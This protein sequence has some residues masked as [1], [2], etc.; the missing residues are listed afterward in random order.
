MSAVGCYVFSSRLLSSTASCHTAGK[1]KGRKKSKKKAAD[2]DSVFAALD[3]NGTSEN[4]DANT[5]TTRVDAMTNGTQPDVEADEAAAF[6]KKKKKSSRQKGK[7]ILE[8][9]FACCHCQPACWWLS[10]AAVLLA[11][12]PH[13]DIRISALLITIDLHSNVST[14]MCRIA[15]QYYLLQ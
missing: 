5:G 4:G 2:L 7:C 8:P 12:K 9:K 10:I 13:Q 15:F 3:Q 11:N 6:G 1:S 14:R